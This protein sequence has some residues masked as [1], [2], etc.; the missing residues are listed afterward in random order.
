M[1]I[2]VGWLLFLSALF[3]SLNISAGNGNLLIKDNN[4]TLYWKG[5]YVI[6]YNEYNS[7]QKF[8]K[9]LSNI[10]KFYANDNTFF[11][12]GPNGTLYGWGFNYAD[13]MGGLL[14]NGSNNIIKHPQRIVLDAPV[15]DVAT[16]GYSHT[17]AVTRGGEVYAWGDAVHGDLGIENAEESMTPQKIPSLHNIVDVAAGYM[18]SLA[19][20]KDGNLYGWGT[21][22][23]GELGIGSSQ[24]EK[25]T[26]VKSPYLNN[27]KQIVAKTWFAAALTQDGKVFMWGQNSDGVLTT[28]NEYESIPVQIKGLDNIISIDSGDE[29]MMALDRNGNVYTW[30]GNAEGELGDGTTQSRSTPQKVSGLSDIIA[31]AAG[32]KTAFA[33]AKDGTLYGWGDNSDHLISK[34]NETI[35]TTPTKIA[36]PFVPCTSTKELSSNKITIALHPGWNFIALPSKIKIDP[37]QFFSNYIL[38]I[39]RKGNWE[40]QSDMA[41]VDLMHKKYIYP[42]EGFWLYTEKNQTKSFLMFDYDLNRTDAFKAASGWAMLGSGRD[43]NIT[44][45][46]LDAVRDPN[47]RKVAWKYTSHG[48]QYYAFDRN[49]SKKLSS[50]TPFDGTIKRGEAFWLLNDTYLYDY[51]NFGSNWYPAINKEK[52]RIIVNSSDTIIKV[53]DLYG[54]Y[55]DTVHTINIGKSFRNYLLYNDYLLVTIDN[56]IWV[57]TLQNEPKRIAEYATN[58]FIWSMKRFGNQLWLQHDNS[59]D[60][61]D[62]SDPEH[63]VHLKNLPGTQYLRL[64]NYIVTVN[65]NEVNIFNRNF[66]KKRSVSLTQIP[67]DASLEV[68]ADGNDVIIGYYGYDNY[69]D[70]STYHSGIIVIDSSDGNVTQKDFGDRDI[71]PFGIID[72]KIYCETQNKYR[73]GGLQIRDKELNLLKE[74]KIDTM[75]FSFRKFYITKN[76]NIL[77]R[78]SAQDGYY[79][80]LFD[81]DLNSLGKVKLFSDFTDDV[82]PIYDDGNML[83]LFPNRLADYSPTIFVFSTKDNTFTLLKR[84]PYQTTSTSLNFYLPLKDDGTSVLI[85][86]DRFEIVNFWKYLGVHP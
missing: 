19:I 39:Y 49:I 84:I 23:Y 83:V 43:G 81:S 10:N 85:E 6:D 27:V 46:T 3:A 67:Q 80:Q 62:I 7:T 4:Y 47:A 44:E 24:D 37:K 5:K 78:Y 51:R 64:Q 16:D 41:K 35:V 73:E 2:I 18:F 34:E 9:L 15:V 63:F 17:L 55:I 1:R 38:W 22:Y 57:Y 68:F 54:N 31:I 14:G 60:I 86:G 52:N 36:L 13:T 66:I 25:D 59:V 77:A 20:D 32:S 61:F 75:V 69:N 29:Y 53:V 11:A 65:K 76:K 33:L 30:G 74:Y 8:Q 79:A 40:L 12:I 72:H 42:G 58:G 70:D 26:P 28:E 56:A 82:L 21:D 48:W 50:Y 71:I 45:L